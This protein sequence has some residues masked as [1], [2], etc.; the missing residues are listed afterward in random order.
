MFLRGD[1][2][3]N[4]GAVAGLP[5]FVSMGFYNAALCAGIFWLWRL[6]ATDSGNYGPASPGPVDVA[7]GA[8]KE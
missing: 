6:R 7:C 1:S 2:Q 5:P 8:P 3:P 4:L